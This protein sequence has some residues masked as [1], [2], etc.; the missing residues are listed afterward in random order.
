MH[1]PSFA[2]VNLLSWVYLDFSH[3][4]SSFQCIAQ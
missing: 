2:E 4:K 3:L 1:R